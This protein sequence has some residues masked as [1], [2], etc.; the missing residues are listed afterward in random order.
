MEPDSQLPPDKSRVPEKEDPNILTVT[1]FG[2]VIAS[3][4][5]LVVPLL[6]SI[7]T[8]SSALDDVNFFGMRPYLIGAGWLIAVGAVI[9]VVVR[10]LREPK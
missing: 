7:G 6:A 8:G 3:L 1:I 4:C 9:F 2:G 5:C 10:R